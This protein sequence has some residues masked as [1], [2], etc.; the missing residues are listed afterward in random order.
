MHNDDFLASDKWNPISFALNTVQQ[1]QIGLENCIANRHCI[2]I[3]ELLIWVNAQTLTH[4]H[5]YSSC[6]IIL[7]TLF[8]LTVLFPIHK[9]AVYT[10]S[11]SLFVSLYSFYPICSQQQQQKISFR[12]FFFQQHTVILAHGSLV[13]LVP[14]RSKKNYWMNER[15]SER[16]EKK[17]LKQKLTR[18]RGEGRKKWKKRRREKCALISM[19]WMSEFTSGCAD[20]NCWCAVQYTMQCS[21][22]TVFGSE[23][24]GKCTFQAF[25]YTVCAT[26]VQKKCARLP[27]LIIIW[28]IKMNDEILQTVSFR[29]IWHFCIKHWKFH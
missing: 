28:R 22:L 24:C 23:D 18:S 14:N 2:P 21:E 27:L 3:S 1:Q 13:D 25:N 7:K 17:K 9:T 29:Q 11:I 16:M 26:I 15:K 19:I 4:T 5:I 10:L 20:T 12:Y 6:I 8:H